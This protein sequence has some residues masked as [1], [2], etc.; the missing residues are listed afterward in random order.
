MRYLLGEFQ[1]NHIP[2]LGMGYPV[3]LINKIYVMCMGM[4]QKQSIITLKT[5]FVL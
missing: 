5:E 1:G 3:S 2:L 4:S